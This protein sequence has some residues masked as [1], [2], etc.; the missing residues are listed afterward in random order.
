MNYTRTFP[1][2]N[3]QVYLRVSSE[4]RQDVRLDEVTSAAT[5]SNQ[6]L[7]SRGQFLVP[8]TESWTRWRYVPL[9]DAAG[10]VQTL[11]F[12][13]TNTVRLTANEARRA[14]TQPIDIGDLHL[15]W[16]LLVPTSAAASSGPWI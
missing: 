6:T 4:G 8:N 3:Y 10:N 14:H 11:S 9:T 16:L 7:A 13:G 12:S 15:N 1:N 5:N 2:T